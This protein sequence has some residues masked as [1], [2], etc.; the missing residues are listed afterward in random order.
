MLVLINSST[1]GVITSLRLKRGEKDKFEYGLDYV[2]ESK[3]FKV[4]QFPEEI[5]FTK[6]EFIDLCEAMQ[7][8][9]RQI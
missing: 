2:S 7:T 4:R 6:E 3:S 8:M 5:I 1:N 9:K